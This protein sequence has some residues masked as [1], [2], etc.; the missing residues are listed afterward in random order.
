VIGAWNHEVIVGYDE[1]CTLRYEGK[2]I[3]GRAVLEQKDLLFRGPLRLSIPI[4]DISSATVSQGWLRVRFGTSEAELELGAAAD[5]W[6]KRILHPPSRLDKLGVKPGM[7]AL[8]LGEAERGFGDELAGRGAAVVSRRPSRPAAD[9]DLVF[10]AAP[11]REA[12]DGVAPLVDALKPDGALWI[13]RPKGSRA[14]TEAE[15]MAA[16]KRAG[17]VDVKV[18]SFS[19]TLTAEKFVIPVA[20]RAARDR[21]SSARRRTR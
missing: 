9:F 17:L 12:L 5:K 7:R 8:V 13:L 2:A 14:I 6:A 19:D 21:P 3:R 10:Y 15:T 1:A 20:K 11:T 4:R 18:V 16:G